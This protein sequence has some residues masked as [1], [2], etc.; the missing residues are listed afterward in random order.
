M[1]SSWHFFFFFEWKG[2]NN[3]M[4]FRQLQYLVKVAEIGNITKAAE[5]LYMTQPAL[6]HYISKVEKEEGVRIFDRSTSPLSL[7]YAGEKYI[8]TAKVILTLNVQLKEELSQISEQHKGRITIGIPPARAAHILPL[9]IPEYIKKF[10]NVEIQTVEHN[11]RQLMV[12]VNKGTVDFAVLPQLEG[13]E[14]FDFIP[15]FEEELVMV[16]AKGMLNESDYKVAEDGQKIIKLE[17]LRNQKFILLKQGHGMRHAIDLLMSMYDYKPDIF[18]ETTNNETAFRMATAGLG[19][20]IVPE[21]CIHTLNHLNEIDVY[22]LSDV[23]LKWTVSAMLRK[24]SYVN[25]LVREC[26]SSISKTCG[27]REF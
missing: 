27:G 15:L 4:D 19:V 1:T 3:F 21:M 13:M 22:K 24:N 25:L 2:V 5:E 20:A 10:P 6:S 12:D 26:I 7:T 8:E 17:E 18:M 23:G 9:F 11:T 16:S 14:D